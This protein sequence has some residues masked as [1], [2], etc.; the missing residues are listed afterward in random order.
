MEINFYTFL[1]HFV[2][3]ISSIELPLLQA[4]TYLIYSYMAKLK[5]PVSKFKKKY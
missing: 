1:T 4:L 2:I 3:I 5:N